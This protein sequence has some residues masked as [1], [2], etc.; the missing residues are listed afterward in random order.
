[1]KKTLFAVVALLTV[2]VVPVK[3]DS[4]P[5]ITDLLGGLAGA[6]G[7]NSSSSD[8]G[9]SSSLGNAIGGLISGLLGDK[10]LTAADIAGVYAYKEPAV[11]FQSDN[12]LQKAGGAVAASAIVDKIAPYY[13]KVGMQKLVVTLNPDNTCRFELGRV[14]LSGTFERDSTVTDANQFIFNFTALGAVKITS[15][16]AD[17]Q[18]VGNN[19]TLTFDASKLISLMNTIAKLSG[20]GT[21][22]A[23][24]KILNSYEGMNCGFSLTRTGDSPVA[25]P[26]SG[27]STAAP[28]ST[29]TATPGKGSGLGS[30]LDRLGR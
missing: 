8:S 11:T 4:T 5:D 15:M 17:V 1:M 14:K 27:T 30:L 22:Q 9:S 29:S 3:A 26:D 19:L 20:Q 2:A 21:I 18:K 23:A 25:V 24:A 7:G 10:Q 12:F 16:T 28:D 13:N 6:V